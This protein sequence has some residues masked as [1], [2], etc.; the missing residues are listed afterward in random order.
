MT[1]VSATNHRLIS[2]RHDSGELGSPLAIRT[3][4]V[5]ELP[6]FGV[7]VTCT[8]RPEVGG[9]GDLIL[10]F[11]AFNGKRSTEVLPR[12]VPIGAPTLTMER[13]QVPE[14]VQAF[15]QVGYGGKA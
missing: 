3:K 1:N 13:G 8:Q 14:Y 10:E 6:T 9:V 15:V 5:G 2:V 11:E 7:W 12:M 4:H